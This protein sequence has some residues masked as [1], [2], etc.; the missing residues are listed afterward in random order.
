MS[1]II[2]SID[3]HIVDRLKL[4][5][6]DGVSVPVFP[7]EA[8]RDRGHLPFPCYTVERVGLIP[9]KQDDRFGI[10]CFEPSVEKRVIQLSNGNVAVG[11]ASYTVRSYP[12]KV[13]L[14]YIVD[15]FAVKK[16]H[17]DALLYMTMQAFKYGYQPCISDQ[18]P[19]FVFTNP[20][21]K[22]TLHI[23]KFNTS[24]LFDV[25]DVS[26]PDLVSYTAA[27][28]SSIIFDKPVEYVEYQ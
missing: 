7:Y 23:P 4:I 20:I 21:T 11:P 5:T 9:Q 3:A 13:S 6:V 15:F 22:D 10:E 19:L 2:A 16:E 28:M 12:Q 18:Y 17:S 27:S 14:R 8:T 26:I 1:D 24:F 25:I